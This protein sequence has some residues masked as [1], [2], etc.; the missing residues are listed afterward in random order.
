ML[1]VLI[2]ELD[3]FKWDQLKLEAQPFV[4]EVKGD[5]GLIE[6]RYFGQWV[7]EYSYFN[8]RGL[9]RL[10]LQKKPMVFSVNK[11]RKNLETFLKGR[12]FKYEFFET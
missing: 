2:D 4:G 7:I 11:V 12:G 10:A 1:K 3:K 8:D 9:L 6:Y 5:D